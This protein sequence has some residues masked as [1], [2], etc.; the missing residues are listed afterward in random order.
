MLTLIED[1]LEALRQLCEKYRVERLDV[2][3]SATSDDF[4]PETS[5]L[6]FLVR[7]KP[8]REGDPRYG[9]GGNY[10]PFLRDL[11]Y[12]FERKV[13]LV[14]ETAMRN[15]YFIESVNETRQNVYAA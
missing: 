14:E 1:K 9:F 6:D 12:L 2:F 13:D 7:F 11:E 5:D 15:P 3:G 10:F 4:D 8:R